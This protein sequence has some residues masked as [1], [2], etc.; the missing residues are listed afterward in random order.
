MSEFNPM[1]R[2]VL[3]EVQ[4]SE[5]KNLISTLENKRAGLNQVVEYVNGI[6]EE[7]GK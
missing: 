5:I 4:E 1:N 2:E 7:Q 3:S 6:L